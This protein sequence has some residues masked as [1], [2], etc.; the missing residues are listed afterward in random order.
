MRYTIDQGI[1]DLLRVELNRDAAVIAEVGKL[2]Y[3]AG[4]GRLCWRSP[5]D[6]LG[7]RDRGGRVHPRPARRVPRGLAVGGAVGG[8]GE[9][10]VGRAGRSHARPAARDR[11][12]DGVRPRGRRFRGVHAR[13]GRGVARGR[14]QSRIAVIENLAPCPTNT[15]GGRSPH[16]GGRN[17]PMLFPGGSSHKCMHDLARSRSST[18][19]EEAADV[20]VA[21]I[22]R[23]SRLSLSRRPPARPRSWWGACSAAASSTARC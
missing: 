13:A 19:G 15:G 22:Q 8:V 16:P 10:P 11:A 4:H 17:S 12:G 21:G 20:L 6:D 9:A 5:W 2:V 23:G 3:I 14:A 7:R 18:P 1:C